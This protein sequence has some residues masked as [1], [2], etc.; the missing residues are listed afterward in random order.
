MNYSFADSYLPVVDNKNVYIGTTTNVY[1]VYIGTNTVASV[2]MT[3]IV[4]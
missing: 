2:G 4:W 3:C 1:N